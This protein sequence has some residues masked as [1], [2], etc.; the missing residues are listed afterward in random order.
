MSGTWHTLLIS[1]LKKQR[2]VILYKF[3]AFQIYIGVLDL[4]GIERHWRV[5]GVGRRGRG[6]G[7][8]TE[9]GTGKGRL[10]EPER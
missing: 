6:I 10:G 7:T 3:K 5:S 1:A 4:P 2:Q 9:T 8:R